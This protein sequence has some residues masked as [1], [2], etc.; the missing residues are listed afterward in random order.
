M[1]YAIVETGGKQYT[2]HLGEFLQVGKLPY[3]PEESLELDRVL[4]VAKDGNVKIGNPVVVGA[5]VKAEVVGHGRLPKITVFKFKS[6]T[7]Y[8]RKVGHRQPY[9]QLKVTEIIDGAKAPVRRR[10]S[11]ARRVQ[12]D[13]S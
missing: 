6:K 4:L 8:S 5:K 2:V 9:T 11:R 10:A 3:A 7:R 1:E 12:E 13:G